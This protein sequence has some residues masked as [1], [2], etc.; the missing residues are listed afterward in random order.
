MKKWDVFISHAS[1][2]KQAFVEPLAVA[3][4]NVGL[5]VWYDK[6]TLRLGDSLSGSIDEG[7]ANCRFGVVV[8]SQAFLS[9]PWTA[10]ELAGLVTREI[11]TGKKILPVWHGVT[12][13]QIIA[14]SPTLAD[15]LAVRTE[16]SSASEIALQILQVVR[17]DIYE[18]TDR[19]SLIA[20][21]DGTAIKQLE[22]DLEEARDELREFQCPDCGAPLIE[23]KDID[24][25]DCDT[26][27][28][29]AFAC[30][31]A[32]GTG[33]KM[34]RTGPRLS[35]V[36]GRPTIW[37]A[38]TTATVSGPPSTFSVGLKRACQSC[39][40]RPSASSLTP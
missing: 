23:N 27:T 8:I 21:M 14:K 37:Q 17:P 28:Y 5:S 11:A 26:E 22:A 34:K 24:V 39:A 36:F 19:A 6:F 7:L 3:L 10:Y 40:N 29:K 35:S 15:K 32:L 4:L 38:A 20:R 31:I 1:E 16:D 30:G 12:R 13:D 33:R 9:K 2:D 18:G 25:A